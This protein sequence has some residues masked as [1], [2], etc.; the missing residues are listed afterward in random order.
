MT[1]T[2]SFVLT[3]LA[4]AGLLSTG[5]ATTSPEVEN[6]MPHAAASNGA[7]PRLLK[8]FDGHTGEPIAWPDLVEAASNADVVIIGEQHGHPVG[9]PFAAAL[10]ED[11]AAREDAAALSMEFFERQH[12]YALD[13]YLTDLI[14]ADRFKKES[15][16]TDSSYPPGHR[17]MIESAKAWGKPVYAANAPRIYST[18]ARKKGFDTLREID[19][20]QARM[21]ELPAEVLDGP[22]RDAFFDVMG[23]MLSHS[24]RP[25]GGGPPA[26]EQAGEQPEEELTP[27]ELAEREAEEQKKK[28]ELNEKIEGY[29]RAQLVWDATM[30]G[31]IIRAL[32]AGRHPVVHVVGQFHVDHDGG[33]LRMVRARRPDATVYTVSVADAWSDELTEDDKDKADCVVYVGPAPER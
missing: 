17:Q 21:F 23:S 12:Q 25:G 7:S 26:A 9:L 14:D 28:D 33:T 3:G 29:F 6:A 19:G 1:R 20:E 15:D 2:T 11:V 22:Y 32:T 10:W 30:S 13:A 5:C 4:L 18:A 16:R 31:T 24:G 27:E 8:M